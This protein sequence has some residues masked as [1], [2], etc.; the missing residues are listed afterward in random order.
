MQRARAFAARYAQ[1]YA[2]FTG[3]E[4]HPP[5]GMIG[6]CEQLH[7]LFL[8]EMEKNKDLVTHCRTAEEITAATGSG[9]AAALLS[10]EGGDLLGCDPG[11]VPIARAWGV[12]LCNPVWNCA[13]ILSGTNCEDET[14]GLSPQ[15]REFIR[16]L[17]ENGIYADVSHLSVRGFWDLADMAQKPIVASHSNA[18]ARCNHR[19]NLTDEQFRV[20]RDSGGVVGINLYSAFVGGDATMD[21]LIAHIEHFLALDG[22]RTVC[23]GGDLDGCETLAGG[24]RGIEDMPRL[25]EALRARHYGDELLENI[26][27]KNLMRLL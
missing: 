17:E 27:W 16:A 14:R 21:D 26:F 1:F 10:I 6:R 24:I 18:K 8:R 11:R 7:T 4:E 13:N 12:R 3:A 19:R 5:E 20:I 2:L 9:K 23:L 22:E 15:G 25:Y